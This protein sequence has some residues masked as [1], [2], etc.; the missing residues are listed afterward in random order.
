MHVLVFSASQDQLAG[1]E[2][3]S[4]QG[5]MHYSQ[6]VTWGAM[7]SHNEVTI[8]Q[9]GLTEHDQSRMDPCCI[10]ICFILVQDLSGRE[11]VSIS[12]PHDSLQ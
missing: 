8:I 6:P 5:V 12:A 1:V 10:I 11:R 3:E 2:K 9:D 4:L 7:V